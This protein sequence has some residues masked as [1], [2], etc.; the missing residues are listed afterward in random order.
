MVSAQLMVTVPAQ[1]CLAVAESLHRVRLGGET[2]LV[3]GNMCSGAWTYSHVSAPTCSLWSF[4]QFPKPWSFMIFAL[5][6]RNDQ[7][8]QSPHLSF[9]AAIVNSD[10]RDRTVLIFSGQTLCLTHMRKPRFRWWTDEMK[11]WERWVFVNFEE[12]RPVRSWLIWE[13]QN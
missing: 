9:C 2:W 13:I 4:P 6:L 1:M 7:S 12:P 8:W 11:E 3:E 10:V 5:I